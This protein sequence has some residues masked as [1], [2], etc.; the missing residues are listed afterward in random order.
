MRKLLI[1]LVFIASCAAAPKPPVEAKPDAGK[2]EERVLPCSTVCGLR[3]D[4]TEASC[5]AL[6]AMEAR[7]LYYFQ[8]EVPEFRP[9]YL[10][11]AALDGYAVKVHKRR[12]G[13]D[14]KCSPDAF[15]AN[16]GDGKD[17]CVYA[18]TKTSEKKIVINDEA[19]AFNALA[20]ELGHVLDKSFG[21]EKGPYHCGWTSRGLSTAILEA[22]YTVDETD[23]KCPAAP[24]AP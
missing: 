5:L 4:V 3:A 21:T 1:A 14:E 22:S 24:K 15:V 19:W 7:A 8:K 2:K 10:A 9:G 11:C 18:Y 23:E 16:L 17:R 12:P 6:N 20:H 13:D